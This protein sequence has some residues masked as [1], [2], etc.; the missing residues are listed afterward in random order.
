MALVTAGRCAP[1]RSASR[2]WERGRGHADAVR[3]HL[4]PALSQVPEGEDET[5]IDPLMMGDGQA[6]G[7]VVGPPSAT[8]ERF[9]AKL[10]PRIEP[11]DQAVVED[12]QFGRLEH[13]PADLGL[14]V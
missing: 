3:P 5:L 7:Q 6:H 12:S 4:P 13:D 2:W 14:D 8:A 11:H 9:E 10:W 1:I